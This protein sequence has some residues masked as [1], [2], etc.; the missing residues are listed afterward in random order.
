M[1]MQ[2]IEEIYIEYFDTVNKYLFCLTHDSDISEELTQETFCKAVKKISTY[3]GDCKMSV[4]LCQ[5][6]KH[7]W[8]D[9]CKKNKHHFN[10]ELVD[11]RN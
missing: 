4:W 11:I 6:A 9:Y 8:Y 5:I 10:E 1:F 3:K 2:N 7:L